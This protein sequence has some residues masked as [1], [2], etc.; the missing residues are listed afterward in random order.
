MKVTAPYRGRRATKRLD[1][2]DMRMLFED[3]RVWCSIGIVTDPGDGPH[4]EILE[5]DVHVE[6]MLQPRLAP[7][8]CRLAAGMWLVPDVGEEVVVMIPE[9]AIE[10][11]PTI[12]DVLS[13]GHVPTG[14]APAPGRAVIA[15]PE[16]VIHDGTGGAAPL[17]TLADLN[18][19]I[20]KLNQLIDAFNLATGATITHAAAPSGTIVLKGK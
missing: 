6:V 3:R 16:V 10:F 11:M 5:S 18:A 8:T 17:P 9:G 20:G 14:Q 13:S 1:M 2:S 7:V 15:R 4:Y 19:T 12:V